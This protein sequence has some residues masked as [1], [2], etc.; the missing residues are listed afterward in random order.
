MRRRGPRFAVLEFAC[1]QQAYIEHEQEGH[2]ASLNDTVMP[3][4]SMQTT[5][6]AKHRIA[7]AAAAATSG[8]SSLNRA[9]QQVMRHLRRVLGTESDVA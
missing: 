1:S 9:L 5:M 8:S 2:F 6:V 4:Q 7:L 3:C